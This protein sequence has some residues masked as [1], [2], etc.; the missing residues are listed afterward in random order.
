MKVEGI[1]G[2]SERLKV[3]KVMCE[4]RRD[5]DDVEVFQLIIMWFTTFFPCH[6]L[7]EDS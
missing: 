4:L 3:T 2:G 7:E 5:E 6:R 1:G